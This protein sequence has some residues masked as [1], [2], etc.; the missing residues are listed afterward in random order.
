MRKI[1]KSLRKLYKSFLKNIFQ[2]I[3]ALI[4]I[5]TLF[6]LYNQ[7]KT[8][9]KP[10]I[11]INDSNAAMIAERYITNGYVHYLFANDSIKKGDLIQEAYT[12]GSSYII[13][14]GA[15]NNS[16]VFNLTNVGLGVAKNVTLSW[17][18]DSLE[19]VRL[20]NDN[21]PVPYLDSVKLEKSVFTFFDREG[22]NY[23]YKNMPPFN[24]TV[25]YILPV[26]NSKEV[27]SSKLPNL[28]L[29]LYSCY[30][31]LKNYNQSNSHLSKE[32]D[33]DFPLLHLTVSYFDIANNPYTKHYSIKIEEGEGVL[34]EFQLK[35]LKRVHFGELEK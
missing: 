2:I 35:M 33:G 29:S 10:D 30:S 17:S 28:Y 16:F 23:Y 5:I 13:S 24:D 6:Y 32:I 31:I 18:F 34:T 12:S 4:S 11:I 14:P 26:N 3:G 1:K 9:L 20:F 19:V 27:I 15:N 8:S 21:L 7:Y 25:N 22:E